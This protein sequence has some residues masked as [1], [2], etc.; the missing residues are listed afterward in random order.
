MRHTLIL[1]DLEGPYRQITQAQ[2]VDFK[3]AQM[4]VVKIGNF[5]GPF[6]NNP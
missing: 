4:A 5:H 6:A 2:G 1:E 3:I